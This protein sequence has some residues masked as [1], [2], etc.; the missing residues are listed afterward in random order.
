MHPSIPLYRYTAI[1]LYRYLLPVTAYLRHVTC[2]LPLLSPSGV[3]LLL[4]SGE[5]P[6]G[7]MRVS[8]IERDPSP[9]TI[10]NPQL[11]P[12]SIDSTTS[13]RAP[14]PSL[15]PQNQRSQRPPFNV[16]GFGNER[17]Q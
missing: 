17:R 5:R 4:P 2:Y 8:A 3:W 15:S 14:R 10:R 12:H 11:I 1:P 13:T 16:Y 6:L 9:T 7:A